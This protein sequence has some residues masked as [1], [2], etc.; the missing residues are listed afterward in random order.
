MPKITLDAKNRG[1]LYELESNSRTPLAK[2]A[3]NVLV[4]KEVVHYRLQRLM[5]LGFITHFEPIIDYYA[6]GL[7]QYRLL[8]SLQN[9]AYHVRS[10][11]ISA[12]E[13]IPRSDVIVYLSSDWDIEIDVWVNTSQSFYSH[14]HQILEKYAQY[15]VNRE[16]YVVTKEHFF[17]H[18][19]LYDRELTECSLS[20]GA[21]KQL[22]DEVNHKILL[23][24]RKD[25]RQ[26]V[27]GLSQ[28]IKLGA[29]ATHTRLRHLAKYGILRRVVPVLDTTMLGYNTYRLSLI[30]GKPS[31]KEKFI[32]YLHSKRQVT[33]IFELIGKKD[34]DVELEFATTLELDQFL[35]ELRLELPY[36]K[37]FEVINILN[38]AQKRKRGG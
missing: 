8:I 26:E 7:K 30:L 34:L 20:D 29:P 10:E 24:L 36:I 22:L 2:I 38:P 35:E 11:I 16:L 13:H 33:K 17:G 37:D 18:R 27:L 25:A 14:Y 12:V 1:L 31:E 3:R 19:Y 28:L 15:I 32:T 9:M 5:K 6:L 21:P 23:H 4:S